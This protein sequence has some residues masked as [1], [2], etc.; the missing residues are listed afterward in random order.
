[1]KVNQRLNSEIVLLPLQV[2]DMTCVSLLNPPASTTAT[3]QAK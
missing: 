3:V 2:E 1:M